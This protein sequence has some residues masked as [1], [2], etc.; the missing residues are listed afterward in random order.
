MTFVFDWFSIVLVAIVVIFCFVGLF[1]GFFATLV[2]LFKSIITIGGAILLSKP[3]ASA[4]LPT[5]IGSAIVSPIDSWLL[6]VNSQAFGMSVTA[7]TDVSFI[8]SSLSE[9]GIPSLFADPIARFALT[10]ADGE[11]TLSLAVSR[12][13]TYYILIVIA[14]LVVLL[15]LNLLMLILRKLT[16]RINKIP[17]VGVFNRILGLLL[18]AAYGFVIVSLIAYATSWLL[19]IREVNDYLG[20]LIGIGN[21]S[22]MS[23]RQVADRKQHHQKTDR[24]LSL[25]FLFRHHFFDFFVGKDFDAVCFQK[26]RGDPGTFD[27]FPLKGSVVNPMNAAGRRT[28]F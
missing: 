9:T 2:T 7:E 25:I 21:D 4:L 13:I 20:T 23:H 10:M 27:R 8:A 24:T 17:F 12:S 5:G 18:G 26:A 16:A 3:I 19:N 14:F 22:K 11:M 15:V 6:S 1:R 28:F